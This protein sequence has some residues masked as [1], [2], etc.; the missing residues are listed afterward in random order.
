MMNR[1]VMFVLVVVVPVMLL[2]FAGPVLAQASPWTQPQELGRGWFPDLAIGLEGRVHVVWNN[3]IE[4]V[5]EG[6]DKPD[7]RDALF[8]R[9][10]R[11]EAW[12]QANDVFV[13]APGISGYTVR[14]SIAIGPDGRLHALFRDGTDVYYA[15]V[16]WDRAWS[17]TEW[18]DP[19]RISVRGAA[20]YTAI[21]IDATGRIHAVWT[22]AVEDDPQNP[23]Q[24]CP[25]CARLFYRFS[26]DGG[27]LWSLPVDLSQELQ[28]ANRPQLKVDQFNRVHIVW[29]AGFDW[30]AGRGRPTSGI[31]RHSADGGA[32]WTAPVE[33]RLPDDTVTQTTLALTN[34][35]NPFVVY[36]SVNG[37]RLYAQSSPN[38]GLTWSG[39]AEVP[40]VQTWYNELDSYSMTTDSVGNIHLVMAGIPDDQVDA[41]ANPWLLH[42]TWN[43]TQWS[44]PEVIMGN[45]LYPEWPRVGVANGNILHV[46]WF[47]RS[48][49]ERFSGNS[50]AYSIWHSRKFLSAPA[51]EGVQLFTPTP[52]SV[53]TAT[54]APPTSTPLPTLEPAVAHM[55]PADGY[56]EW[57]RQGL[58]TVLMALLPLL[59]VIVLFGGVTLRRGRRRQGH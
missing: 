29:D 47:T 22:E 17:A 50:S 13:T 16:P 51:G 44:A 57:E 48:E 11:D 49:E 18:S 7:R 8:Y 31:Y 14:N 21:A 24:E 54:S 36:Q 55:P 58:A 3:G 33:F 12:T 37:R 42:L 23:G 2:G 20:Y 40:G 5:V 30:Y 38:G 39:P 10:L 6:R 28:G 9:E 19:I 56:P 35:G 27:R 45:E 25:G 52:Q 34:Q 53:P 4:R 43:G 15:G 46:V 1:H 41:V 32:T 59:G 26:T